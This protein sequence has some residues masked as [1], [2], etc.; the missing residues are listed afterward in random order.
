M[1]ARRSHT[2]AAMEISQAPLLSSCAYHIIISSIHRSQ[3]TPSIRPCS[4]CPRTFLADP[5]ASVAPP[6]L[7]ATQLNLPHVSDS[8]VSKRS[9]DRRASHL[10]QGFFVCLAAWMVD[11][12]AVTMAGMDRAPV[13]L[14]ACLAARCRPRDYSMSLHRTG[15]GCRSMRPQQMQEKYTNTTTLAARGSGPYRI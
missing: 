12:A 11:R 13:P 10:L 5:V 6:H 3:T 2:E 1:R 14:A 8:A 9:I 15:S 4:M 7:R